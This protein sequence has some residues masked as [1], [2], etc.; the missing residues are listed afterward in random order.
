MI[1][2][3]LIAV[4]YAAAVLFFISLAAMAKRGDRTQELQI[5][6]A[7]PPPPEVGESASELRFRPSTR[8]RRSAPA[9]REAECMRLYVSGGEPSLDPVA[10]A[11]P[12]AGR[13]RFRRHLRNR[14]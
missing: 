6:L 10:I 3:L 12:S 2:I 9:S 7:Y 11:S 8:V 4:G 5:R 1:T 13:G 14:A